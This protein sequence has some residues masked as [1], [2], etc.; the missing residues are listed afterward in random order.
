MFIE[1]MNAGSLASFIKMNNK[2]I[3]E[4]IISYIIREILKGLKCIHKLSQI[5]R[6]IKS[7]NILISKDGSIKIADFGYALQLTA[8]KVSARGLA[9]TA[10]W[11]AP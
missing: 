5:H 6:D 4:K 8:D 3:A 1:Y 9:G 2:N 10:S 11:M 7:D